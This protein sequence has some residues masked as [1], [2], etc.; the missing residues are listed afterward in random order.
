MLK[1]TINTQTFDIQSDKT[2][3]SVNSQPFNWDMV[4]IK[5][6]NFHIIYNHKSFNAEVLEANY[7]TKSFLI[8]VNN[9]KHTVLLK[10]RFD[11]LLDQLG[12]SNA[13]TSKANDLKAPMPGLIVDVKVQVGDTVKKGDTILILEAMKME[14]IL[15]ASGDGKIKAI[16][17]SAKQNVEKNQ[18]MIEFE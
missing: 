5:D 8:K 15:K 1:A 14:N 12:M 10:D 11:I 4:E 17:I 3:I 18:V 6:G 7:Q 2:G 13:N 16:K 9:T